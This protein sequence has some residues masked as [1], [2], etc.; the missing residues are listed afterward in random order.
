MKVKKIIILIM[1]ICLANGMSAQISITIARQLAER[2]NN[3]M[4]LMG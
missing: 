3:V 1:A 2:G 4:T